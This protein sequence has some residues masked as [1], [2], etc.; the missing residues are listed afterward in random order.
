MKM[1]ARVT[2]AGIGGLVLGLAMGLLLRGRDGEPTSAP[3]PA[4]GDVAAAAPP[5]LDAFRDELAR[6]RAAR[7]ALQADVDELRDAVLEWAAL[8]PEESLTEEADSVDAR[9]DRE[10]ARPE[11]SPWFDADALLET[12]LAAPEVERLRGRF[13]EHELAELYLRDRASREGWLQKP[14]YRQALREMREAFR[15]EVGEE[16]YDRMLYAA[17]RQNR[18]RIVDVLPDSPAQRAGLAAGDVVLSYA[19]ERMFEILPLTQ[20]TRG[21]HPGDPT[22]IR[23]VRNGEE[24]RVYV[25]RG[26]LGVRL[27]PGRLP[28]AP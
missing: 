21:G 5:G 13:A 1:R 20:A 3:A 27:G 18:V 6:E 17:G 14:G 16:D 25:P 2:A 10:A 8:L 11:E 23:Y 28:P 4:A 19:G 26:P 12:G 7:E 15:A 24:R 9:D 22:E